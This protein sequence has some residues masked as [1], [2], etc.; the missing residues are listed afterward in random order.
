MA[1]N[2]WQAAL[3]RK[4]LRRHRDAEGQGDPV[5]TVKSWQADMLPRPFPTLTNRTNPLVRTFG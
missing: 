2:E 3:Q 1:T 4:H 5:I